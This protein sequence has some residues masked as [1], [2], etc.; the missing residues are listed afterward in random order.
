MYNISETTQMNG[1]CYYSDGGGFPLW[2]AGQCI[3]RGQPRFVWRVPASSTSG[4]KLYEMSYINWDAG[5]PNNVH[6]NGNCKESVGCVNLWTLHSHR[7]ND[8]TCVTKICSVCEID[9]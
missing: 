7:W 4:E 1:R 2:T 9:L 8:Q 6:G 5:E 3:H